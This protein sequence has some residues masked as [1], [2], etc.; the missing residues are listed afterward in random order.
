[1]G[2]RDFLKANTSDDSFSGHQRLTFP[3][4]EHG[5]DTFWGAFLG[6][7]NRFWNANTRITDHEKKGTF[8]DGPILTFP[9]ETSEKKPKGPEPEKS[10]LTYPAGAPAYA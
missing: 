5:T 3:V 8:E 2:F 7:W 6:Y 10:K 9:Y 1:M 4:Q